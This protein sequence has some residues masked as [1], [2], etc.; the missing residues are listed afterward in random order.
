MT[1]EA[2]GRVAPESIC[3]RSLK[4]DAHSSAV[5]IFLLWTCG[6]WTVIILGAVFSAA[7][8]EGRYKHTAASTEASSPT[9]ILMTAV[10]ALRLV[11]HQNSAGGSVR[12]ASV[13][14]VIPIRFRDELIAKLL[15]RS[16]LVETK[17]RRLSLSRDLHQTTL[18]DLARDL[19]LTLGTSI[20][21]EKADGPLETILMRLRKIQEDTMGMSLAE[22]A[23]DAH[24]DAKTIEK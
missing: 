3:A 14:D 20:S 2:K 10:S 8:S 1:M 6:F 9:Q 5:L 4:P 16:Y 22:I 15:G 18:A 17:D 11:V 7:R 19:D 21:P 13:A 12:Y 24:S 23:I